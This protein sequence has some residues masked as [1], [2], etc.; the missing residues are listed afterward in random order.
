V[1]GAGILSLA[2]W[3]GKLISPQADQAWLQSSRRTFRYPLIGEFIIRVAESW[4]RL[5]ILVAIF[6]TLQT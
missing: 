4:I 3:A 2:T 5:I 6:V 1:A